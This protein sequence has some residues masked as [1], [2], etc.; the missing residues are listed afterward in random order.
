[1]RFGRKEG[2]EKVVKVMEE[3]SVGAGTSNGIE[4]EERGREKNVD[5]RPRA[6]DGRPRWMSIKRTKTMSL[7]KT[8]SKILALRNILMW[9]IMGRQWIYSPPILFL[10]ALHHNIL[11]SLNVLLNLV[12]IPVHHALNVHSQLHLHPHSQSHPPTNTLVHPNSN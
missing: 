11:H 8:D 6:I 3:R 7:E 10:L 9:L 12:P 5:G 4:I 2:K 1:M